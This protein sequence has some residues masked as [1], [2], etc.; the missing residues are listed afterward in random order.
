MKRHQNRRR[1]LSLLVFWTRP[2]D[3]KDWT[4]RPPA[5]IDLID[6]KKFK[7]F[8]IWHQIK[9]VRQP[10]SRL[11]GIHVGIWNILTRFKGKFKLGGITRSKAPLMDPDPFPILLVRRINLAY[12]WWAQLDRKHVKNGQQTVNDLNLLVCFFVVKIGEDQW[13]QRVSILVLDHICSSS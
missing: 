8:N 9:T 5:L 12:L 6:S 13:A 4:T 1:S 7:Q 10:N 2:Y 11:N 3:P